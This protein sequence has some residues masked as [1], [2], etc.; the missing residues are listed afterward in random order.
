LLRYVSLRNFAAGTIQ[1]V[2]TG[3]LESPI[4]P[5]I[6]I[7]ELCCAVLCCARERRRKEIYVTH[8]L[9]VTPAAQV[10][11]Q[12][13]ERH[14]RRA[15]DALAVDRPP[16]GL[17]GAGKSLAG[18]GTGLFGLGDS[19]AGGKNPVGGVADVEAGGGASARHLVVAVV[20]GGGGGGVVMVMV[21]VW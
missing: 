3:R 11:L 17:L 6:K 19:V 12:R 20:V 5:P 7:L 15:L 10:A 21:V 4:S 9:I 8:R 18:T 2:A 14:E 16:D 1:A 13:H